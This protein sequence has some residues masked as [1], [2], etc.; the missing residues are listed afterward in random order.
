MYH[1]S[2]LEILI[3][4][5][6]FED[7]DNDGYFDNEFKNGKDIM[8]LDFQYMTTIIE[9]FLVKLEHVCNYFSIHVKLFYL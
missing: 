8:T 9:V 3:Q 1:V 6:N 2:M 7:L 4:N 5:E